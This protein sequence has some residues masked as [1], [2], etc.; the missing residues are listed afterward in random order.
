[1]RIANF[2]EEGV[3]LEI[4]F[5]SF[6]VSHEAYFNGDENHTAE[7]YELIL[8]KILRECNADGN[9]TLDC[10]KDRY[11]VRLKSDVEVIRLADITDDE[12]KEREVNMLKG[13][14][15]RRIAELK[16]NLRD[17]DYNILK[18]VE[19]VA[20]LSDL[21]DVL[22][23]RKAWREEINELEAYEYER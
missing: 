8:R 6:D 15:A 23:K 16:R 14:H 19:G 3:T 11:T 2:S 12:R 10:Y 18:V 21:A 4:D 17:T 13:E 22:V 5:K 20:K 9:Y 7:E 1:M